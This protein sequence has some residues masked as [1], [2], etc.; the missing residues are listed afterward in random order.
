VAREI[1]ARSDGHDLFEGTQAFVDRNCRGP[2]YD[3]GDEDCE[4]CQ[5]AFGPDRAEAIARFKLREYCYA[6]IKAKEADAS[7]LPFMVEAIRRRAW[8]LREPS[9]AVTLVCPRYSD[10]GKCN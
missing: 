5:K 8:R 9:N 6:E 3:C 1:M 10:L 4:E 2:S 7:E